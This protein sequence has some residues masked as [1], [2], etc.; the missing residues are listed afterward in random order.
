VKRTK[1][2]PKQTLTTVVGD[3]RRQ[4]YQPVFTP[5]GQLVEWRKVKGHTL[6]TAQ[7]TVH[8][9]GRVTVHYRSTTDGKARHEPNRGEGAAA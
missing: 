9:S 4:G 5:R 8:T 3:L 6:H 7:V 1:K 2:E